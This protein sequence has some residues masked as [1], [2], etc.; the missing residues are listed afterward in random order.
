MY[1][2]CFS[3]SSSILLYFFIRQA[4]LQDFGADSVVIWQTFHVGLFLFGCL[5]LI[6][7]GTQKS[8]F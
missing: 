4:E 7:G 8:A 5:R 3:G 2:V 1:S 6:L